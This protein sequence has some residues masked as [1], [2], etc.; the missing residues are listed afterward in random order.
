MKRE[1]LGVIAAL[2]SLFF[3][4]CADIETRYNATSST[5]FASRDPNCSFDIY[6]LV[7][8]LKFQEIGVITFKDVT[9]ENKDSAEFYGAL[10]TGKMGDYDKTRKTPEE[11]KPKATA[12]DIDQI[13]EYAGPDVCRNGGNGLILS[14]PT[15]EGKY[16]QGTVV[17]VEK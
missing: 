4:A 13:K 9:E 10:A 12:L 6:T 16:V 11:L 1:L 17:L 3:T 14:Q 7:P 15:S 2:G 8:Q 5:T